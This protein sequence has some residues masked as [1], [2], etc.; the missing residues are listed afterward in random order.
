MKNLPAS[1]AKIY[2]RLNKSSA[3]EKMASKVSDIEAETLTQQK[4]AFDVKTFEMLKE[5]SDEFYDLA[6]ERLRP[7]LGLAKVGAVL[8]EIHRPLTTKESV[9]EDVLKLASVGTLDAL[10]SNLDYS[11]LSPSAAK[12]A[13]DLKMIN[14]ECGIDTIRKLVG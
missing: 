14:A 5:S 3:F 13:E 4:L 2:R 10:L 6:S 1:L 9:L 7:S 11:S 8:S 12:L